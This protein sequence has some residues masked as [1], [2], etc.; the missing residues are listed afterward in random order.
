MKRLV[1]GVPFGVA[2]DVRE[3]YRKFVLNVQNLS[4]GSAASL[5][6]VQIILVCYFVRYDRCLSSFRVTVVVMFEKSYE[7]GR[8]EFI[9]LVFF[10]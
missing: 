7:I 2:I 3:D 1:H 5:K 9:S 10:G 4:S 8:I 6:S